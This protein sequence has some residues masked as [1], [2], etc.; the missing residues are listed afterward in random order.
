MRFTVNLDS[1]MVDLGKDEGVGPFEGP[2]Y[3]GG[4]PKDLLTHPDITEGFIGCF[5]GLII[6][7]HVVNLYNHLSRR[8]PDIV[9]DCQPSCSSNP[10]QNGATCHENWGSYNCECEN[11][12]AHSGT[13]CENNLNQNSM[14]FITSS[15]CY[16][17]ATLGNISDP[18]LAENILLSF[19]TYQSEALLLYS[20][21]HL[22]NF[23][24]LHFEK[25]KRVVFTF[26]SQRSIVQGFVEAPDLA[27]GRIV[28]VFVDRHADYTV[29]QVNGNNVTIPHPAVFLTTYY[30]DPWIQGEQL[31]LV[32][33]ARG[34]FES[35]PNSQMYLGGVDFMGATTNLPGLVGCLQ[36]L[37]I[38]NVQVDLIKDVENQN[39][40]KGQ[41]RPGCKM[42]CD[43]KPCHHSGLCIEDWK[44][45][46]TSCDCSMTSYQGDV[47]QTDIGAQFDGKAWI[48]YMFMPETSGQDRIS[49]LL[50][51]S[52]KAKASVRQAILLVQYAQS[53]HYVLVA[54]T[55]EGALQIQEN[56]ASAKVFG[57]QTG[58]FADG[59]RHWLHYKRIE[60]DARV[61][62]DGKEY[63]LT[64]TTPD[65]SGPTV[66]ISS[67]LVVVGGTKRDPRFGDY[68][69]F[70]GCVSNV[71][72]ELRTL[73]IRPLETY[74]GY[75]KGA[76][77][78][79]KVYGTLR[80]GRC[81]EFAA[82]IGDK[83]EAIFKPP[84]VNVPEWHRV[85]PVLVP[86]KNNF[87]HP[88]ATKLLYA[89][90]TSTRVAVIMAVVLIV[91]L[92]GV[93]LYAWRLQKRH[94]H[95][96]LR[97]DMSYFRRGGGSYST[98]NPPKR[99]SN[100]SPVK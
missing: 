68:G 50:A 37:R 11:S 7:N 57:K 27:T 22:N 56:H 61:V 32:K 60:N 41:I 95:Q 24:Q 82:I 73:N 80:E 77:E 14:T 84:A 64:S 66:D 98:A 92:I 69:D 79:V 51:F 53:Q 42:M 81:A 30:K 23:V 83:T 93:F 2:L 49:I 88:Q 13:N 71:V 100:N 46:L 21:N 20:F 15:S 9:M 67:S 29:L 4:A 47:C 16:H 63:V 54:V 90:A 52:T 62:V 1:V 97:E 76:L 78:K 72:V 65:T 87:F 96:K 8:V 48:E 28:Q 3:I 89:K 19:R 70:Q 59:F 10:C 5:R 75:Q 12:L 17:R 38:G 99:K 34:T 85:N 39:V 58:N 33:P 55:P 43:S 44:N 94:K 74:F 86:Y 91:V 25:R 6:N 18:V 40:T 36:G 35:V 26:N 31:E 45:N